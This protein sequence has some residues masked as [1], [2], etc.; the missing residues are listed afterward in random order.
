MV[1][2]NWSAKKLQS[3]WK[4]FY[5]IKN[6]RFHSAATK[7][8]GTWRCFWEV[9][10]YVIMNHESVCIQSFVRGHHARIT[11][12]SKL[13]YAIIIQSAIRSYHA[14]RVTAELKMSKAYLASH[15]QCLKE[16]LAA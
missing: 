3:W 4:V 13:G 16:E 6:R 11:T 14:Y 5:H 1:I 12:N 8:Q 10:Q 9:K 7:I 2:K 15:S